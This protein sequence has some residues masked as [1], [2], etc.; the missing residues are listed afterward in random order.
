M[1][2]YIPLTANIPLFSQSQNRPRRDIP[3]FKDQQRS[4]QKGPRANFN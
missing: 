1:S 4:T 3:Q 2:D